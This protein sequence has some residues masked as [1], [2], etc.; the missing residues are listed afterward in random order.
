[1]KKSK[2]K[3]KRLNLDVGLAGGGCQIKLC[4]ETHNLGAALGPATLR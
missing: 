3:N 4:L 1:M 2:G